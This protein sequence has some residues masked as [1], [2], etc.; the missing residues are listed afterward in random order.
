[1]DIDGQAYTNFRAV[2]L[3]GSVVMRLQAGAVGGTVRVDHMEAA[4]A[5]S[6]PD[7]SGRFP[8]AGTFAFQLPALA[9]T[10]SVQST[11]V[12]VAGIRTEDGLVVTINR[13]VSAGYGEVSVTSGAT[14][15]ILAYAQPGAGV[16]TLSFFNLGVATGYVEL[17][18]S[19]CAVR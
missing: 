14:S 18:G 6:F 7:K 16:I 8:V 12:T 1:M 10:T 15:R 3:R 4:R 17:V 2:N 13:G 9:S 11:S 19:Y 5:W